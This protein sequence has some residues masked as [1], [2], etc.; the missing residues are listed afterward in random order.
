MAGLIDQPG[1][2]AAPPPAEGDIERDIAAAIKAVLEQ[3]YEPDPCQ[4]GRH[5]LTS[6]AWRTPGTY[7]CAACAMPVRVPVPL[8]LLPLTAA[9]WP[10]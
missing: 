2:W 10:G 6:K 7:L 1:S 4:L 8:G 9:T 3:P 5:L